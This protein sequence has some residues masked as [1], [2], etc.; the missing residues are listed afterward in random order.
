MMSGVSYER[1]DDSGLHVTSS[2]AKG[3]AKGGAKGASV[4]PVDTIVVCA[5]QEPLVMSTC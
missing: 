3:G 1:V 5:G 4:L 2:K